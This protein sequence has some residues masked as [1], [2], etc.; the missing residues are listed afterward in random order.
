MRG[1]DWD[2]V[3]ERVKAS[4][5]LVMPAGRGRPSSASGGRAAPG[6]SKSVKKK[7]ARS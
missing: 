4:H 7:T 6:R 1:V 5:A 2:E 3:A